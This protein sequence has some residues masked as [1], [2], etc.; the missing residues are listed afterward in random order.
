MVL[1]TGATG[2]L[3]RVVVLELLNRGYQVRAAKR[4][5]SDLDEVRESFS[6][7]T[8]S[9]DE[10]FDKIEWIDA[11]FD[12]IHSVEAAVNGVT[13]V[14]HCA[15]K[16][17]FYPTDE[18]EIYSTN[19]TGTANLLYACENSSVQD[20]CFISSV[21]VLDGLNE[22]GL[23][24]E[25]S[26]FNPKLNHSHYA[27]SKHLSEMEVWRAS[28]E[29]LNTVILNPGII[30]GSGNWNASSGKL[31]KTIEKYP[32][33]MPGST[34]YVDVRDV[35]E[36]SVRLMEENIFGERFIVSSENRT[37]AD[38]AS[39]VRRRLGKPKPK[40]LSGT[41]LD[42][43]YFLQLIFGG[44]FPA[45]RIMN[46][47]N[48]QTVRSRSHVSNKKI[49]EQLNWDFIPVNESLEFHLSNYI[50]HKKNYNITDE[51]R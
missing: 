15:G 51:Y 1:V 12:D 38:I 28:A 50:S 44:L 49:T 33:A 4:P 8:D 16:V 43:G 18:K 10:Y 17:S 42:A 11:D 2:I 41:I 27:I 48:L 32:Y 30:L 6:Y 24:D 22:A 35:A 36:I 14:Y 13:S 21:A 5:S 26:D 46:R 29:G 37:Y 23:M 40:V 39:R 7:Y 3:G 19:V 9:P 20:F 25:G 45:L 47:T 31:F 34:S